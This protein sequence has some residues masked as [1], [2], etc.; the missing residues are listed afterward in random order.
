MS[1]D[2]QPPVRLWPYVTAALLAVCLGWGLRHVSIR[3]EPGGQRARVTQAATAE[4]S[5]QDV[6]AGIPSQLLDRGQPALPQQEIPSQPLDRAQPALPQESPV[7]KDAPT[8]AAVAEPATP[9]RGVNP[10]APAAASGAPPIVPPSSTVSRPA[11]PST[12]LDKLSGVTFGDELAR[13]A[14]RP[15]TTPPP[16]AARKENLPPDW[17]TFVR[18]LLPGGHTVR[19]R[20]PNPTAV[21]I[22]L[23]SEGA[24]VDLDVPASHVRSVQVPAGVYEVF[25]CYQ[26]SRR[27]VFQGDNVTLRLPGQGVEIRLVATVGGNYGMRRYRRP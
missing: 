13:K 14:P 25:L 8:A 5:S 18:P 6:T 19:I 1:T 17:P 16:A 20:N 22:G 12:P 26:N 15:E 3:P 27:E 21:T 9:R 10:P 4:A 2:N 23:R 11:I 7:R 24:G